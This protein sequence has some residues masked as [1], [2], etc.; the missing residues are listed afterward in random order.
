MKWRHSDKNDLGTV[1]FLWG[2]GGGAGGIWGGACQKNGF[3]GGA[4]QKI[5]CVKGGGSPKKTAFKFGND[6]IC[7]NAYISARMPKNSVSNVLWKFK[8][9]RG[10]QHAPGHP[11]FRLPRQL[12]PT[13]YFV[14]KYSQGNVNSFWAS[15]G[16]FL[17][18]WTTN[19]SVQPNA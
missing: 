13:N 2:Y 6:S 19:N 9:S 1:H 16:L 8:F 15:A 14:T 10:S 3:Q 4:R 18:D 17:N 11:Y 12:Y 7:N 5:W